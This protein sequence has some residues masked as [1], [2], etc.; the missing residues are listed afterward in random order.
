MSGKI[1][2]NQPV[3]I[4]LTCS[5]DG[6]IMSTAISATIAWKKPD[7][8][9]GSWVANIDNVT[10]IVSYEAAALDINL[11][12]TWILQPIVTFPASRVIPGT[13]T[14]MVVS[15]RFT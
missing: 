11:A 1:Y 10:G 14:Q 3:D 13:I 7:R 8:T 12:G 6:V 2:V 5:L 9:E 15:K 4:K